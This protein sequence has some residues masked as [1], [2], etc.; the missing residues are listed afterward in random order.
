MCT[1]YIVYCMFCWS[2][3]PQVWDMKHIQILYAMIAHNARISTNR[4]SRERECA[5]AT[6]FHV[7]QMVCVHVLQYAAV[8]Q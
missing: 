7:R 1:F 8:E 2:H 6:L 4:H 5:R 3:H